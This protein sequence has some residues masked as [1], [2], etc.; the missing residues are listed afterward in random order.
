[1][2]LW[3]LKNSYMI[4]ISNKYYRRL[5]FNFVGAKILIKIYPYIRFKKYL[6][7]YSV[8]IFQY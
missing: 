7:E 8:S 3:E 2:T 5:S 4:Y 1:M 6:L